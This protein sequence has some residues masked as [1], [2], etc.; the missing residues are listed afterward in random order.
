MG[1]EKEFKVFVRWDDP[2]VTGGEEKF[3]WVPLREAFASMT[4]GDVYQV[5]LPA[6]DDPASPKNKEVW[7]WQQTAASGSQVLWDAIGPF[8]Y[9]D[10]KKKKEAK[11]D[12]DYLELD[13]DYLVYGVRRYFQELRR[14][15]AAKK[16]VKGEVKEENDEQSGSP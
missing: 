4:A 9:K 16:A 10:V 3:E 14:L 8:E 11:E 2:D 7:V 12:Y 1:S 6:T 5:F 13:V 15:R